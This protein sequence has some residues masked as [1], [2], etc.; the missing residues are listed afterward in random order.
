MAKSVILGIVRDILRFKIAFF[1]S[2]IYWISEFSVNIIFYAA[3]LSPTIY[4]RFNIG[5]DDI[6]IL[7]FN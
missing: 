3:C 5:C 4:L 6:V 1:V 7:G 2:R